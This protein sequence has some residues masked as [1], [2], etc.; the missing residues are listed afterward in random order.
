MLEKNVKLYK[1]DESN[2]KITK[3]DEGIEEKKFINWNGKTFTTMLNNFVAFDLFED[4]DENKKECYRI[5]KD[6]AKISKLFGGGNSV[7]DEDIDKDL[8]S[9]IQTFLEKKH[10]AKTYQAQIGNKVINRI[11]ILRGKYWYVCK[12]GTLKDFPLNQTFMNMNTLLGTA[13]KAN[14]KVKAQYENV[15]KVTNIIEVIEDLKP[16]QATTKK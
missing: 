9:V 6:Y 15:K 2:Y 3:N 14:A 1:A 10:K 4:T 13:T 7:N 12:N 11:C 5:I 16:E 8:E